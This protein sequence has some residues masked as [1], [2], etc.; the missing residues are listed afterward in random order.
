MPRGLVKKRPAAAMSSIVPVQYE[1]EPWD[2][3]GPHAT[4][5]WACP[6][7]PRCEQ[8]MWADHLVNMLVGGGYLPR[9][10]QGGS[11]QPARVQIWSDCSG[12]NSEM[13]ALGNLNDAFDRCLNVKVDW[14][15]YF[16]CEADVASL[17]FAERNHKPLHTSIDMNQRSL[18]APDTPAQFWCETCKLNHDLPTDGID[19]YVGTYPCSPWSRRGKRT[20]FGHPAAELFRIG[21]STIRHMQPAAW[22][23]ELGEVPDEHAVDHI[24][25]EITQGINMQDRQPYVVQAL[26][27]LSPLASGFPMR[28]TRLFFVGWR[29]DMGVVSD[30]IKPLKC[31]I[32]HPLPLQ[33]SYFGFLKL[34]RSVD[35]SRVGQYPTDKELAQLAAVTGDNIACCCSVAPMVVCRVHICKCGNCGEDGLH[36]AWRMRMVQHMTA[37]QWHVPE[38]DKLRYVQVLEMNGIVCPAQARCRTWLNILAVHPDAQPLNDTLMIADISQNPGFGSVLFDGV[39]PTLTT[40]SALHCLQVGHALN[41]YQLSSLMGLSLEGVD[42]RGVQEAWMR[43]RLGLG[44]HIAS[45]GLVLLAVMATPLDA[46]WRGQGATYD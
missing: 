31:L 26:R 21:V 45:F 8:V 35:L 2:D 5:P 28:R 33:H 23:M 34:H 13:F 19:L 29:G 40:T 14:N 1:P 15:L 24:Q 18:G 3:S 41:T 46:I 7:G 39:V 36:C 11:T 37:K 10:V 20:G 42:L 27:N 44:V 43:R 9:H 25:H 6:N 32:D 17:G 4:I 12:I 22:I 16:C 30:L 38:S